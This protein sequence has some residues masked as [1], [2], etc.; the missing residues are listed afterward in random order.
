MTRSLF[1]LAAAFVLVAVGAVTFYGVHFTKSALADPDP[2][3]VN[4]VAEA[5]RLLAADGAKPQMNRV[6]NGIS[7]APHGEEPRTPSDFAEGRGA[8]TDDGGAPSVPQPNC[9][10]DNGIAQ[11]DSAGD[12]SFSYPSLWLL[13]DEEAMACGDTVVKLRR[14]FVFAD[15]YEGEV[16]VQR[17]RGA[18]GI[19][20]R[21]S[22]E[23]ASGITVAGKKAVHI[24]PVRTSSGFAL[25]SEVLVVSE[26][27]G[28]T[29]IEVWESDNTPSVREVASQV[30]GVARFPEPLPDSN[31]E[32]SSDGSNGGGSS[33][34]DSSGSSD[35][36]RFPDPLP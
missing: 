8:R 26:P 30:Y 25:D 13:A 7:V 23:R 16:E 12:L 27:W 17:L 22:A 6:F 21:V 28:L 4:N 3:P 24:E 34:G 9:R 18:L 15:D 31:K 11:T 5:D 32:S 19:N 36:S 14:V 29:L 33:S 35:S 1:S 10:G 2:P 20:H